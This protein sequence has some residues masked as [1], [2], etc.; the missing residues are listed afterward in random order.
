MKNNLVI[1]MCHC[2][3]DDKIKVLLENINKIKTEGFDIMMLSHI[4]VSSSIQNKVDYFIYDKSNP[5]ITYPYRL[6]L[7][8]I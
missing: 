1:I 4:P 5:T 6:S 7:I 3:D 2:N 8:H